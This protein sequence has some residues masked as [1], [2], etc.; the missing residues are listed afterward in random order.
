M[1]LECYKKSEDFVDAVMEV[2]KFEIVTFLQMVVDD[3]KVVET[4]SRMFL[5]LDLLLLSLLYSQ[6]L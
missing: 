4:K 3:I 1:V 5:H 2:T 6:S